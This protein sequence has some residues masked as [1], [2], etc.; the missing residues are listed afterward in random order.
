MTF[1]F[2]DISEV[3]EGSSPDIAGILKKSGGVLVIKAGYGDLADGQFGI[4]RI[5]AQKANVRAL[6]IYH[7]VT[8]A[9][10]PAE[11]AQLFH[12]WVGKLA[13]NEFPIIDTEDASGSWS[14]SDIQSW[15]ANVTKLCGG[16]Y[17][18]N[19][20]NEGYVSEHGL[21]SIYTD[22]TGWVAKYGTSTAPA[23]DHIAWQRWADTYTSGNPVSWPGC[24]SG[25]DTSVVNLTPDQF[26]SRVLGSPAPTPTEDEDMPSGMLKNGPF[27]S[28]ADAITTLSWPAG[29]YNAAGFL[30]DNGRISVPA[31]KIRVALS[32]AGTGAKAPK[33]AY[34]YTNPT[35]KKQ[36][37]IWDSVTVDGTQQKTVVSFGDG[38]KVDGISIQRL[39]AG[40]APIGFDIG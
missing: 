21:N 16:V 23:P 24:P 4:W 18:L 13:A 22:S 38:N 11:S 15:H 32:W 35:T 29:K 1:Y 14:V 2:P 19:Y 10:S 26:V 6:G 20:A 7:F 30:S 39:D 27:A 3:G 12:G 17:G 33:G 40:T 9:H 8:S 28:A 5:A 25:T 34:V 31:G 37:V 36:W